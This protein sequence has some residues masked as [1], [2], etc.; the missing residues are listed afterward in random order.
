M[1]AIEN[2]WSVMIAHAQKY[3]A[4]WFWREMAGLGFLDSWTA[5]PDSLH[6]P[7][8]NIIFTSET[9]TVCISPFTKQM[10]SSMVK[11]VPF[12]PFSYNLLLQPV[13][14][15]WSLVSVIK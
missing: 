4:L 7:K 5:D 11:L 8:H 2:M 13:E 1:E 9:V 14:I 10:Q 15:V 6:S 12:H 3:T